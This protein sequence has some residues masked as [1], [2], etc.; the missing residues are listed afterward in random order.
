MNPIE[1]SFGA[2]G[3]SVAGTNGMSPVTDHAVST[4]ESN[5]YLDQDTES[6]LNV[7]YATTGQ[8]GKISA[9]A[10]PDRTPFEQA[11]ISGIAHGR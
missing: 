8:E 1:P 4:S 9:Y 10:P 7:A 11:L 5:G 2:K 6:L 3:F